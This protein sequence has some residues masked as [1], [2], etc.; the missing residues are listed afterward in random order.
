M[1]VV[2]ARLRNQR[3]TGSTIRRPEDVVAWMGALQAQDFAGARWAVGQR[4]SQATDDAVE[5]AF[6]DGRVLRTHVL[7]PTWH[8][9]HP[10]DIR[11]MLALTGPRVHQA[12]GSSYRSHDL[13][14]RRLARGADVICRA[15][16]GGRH[17]TRAELGAV[18]KAARL[19]HLGQPLAYLMMYAEL[20]ALVCSGP[21][22][23]KQF[24]YALMD[25]R[26]GGSRPSRQ[27]QD[28]RLGE[29]VRRYAASHG[30]ATLRDFAWWSGLTMAQ[31]RTGIGVAAS[32]LET[33][34]IDGRRHWW[35]AEAP[36]GP[37][38]PHGAYLLPNYDEFLIAFKDRQWSASMTALAPRFGPVV[39]FP[40]QI[41]IGGRVEGAWRVRRT[42]MHAC[43]ELTLYRPI[44]PA[45][46]AAVQ[47]AVDRY[48]AFLK[49]PV[50]AVEASAE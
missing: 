7:R 11:W 14:A 4:M 27:D 46:R 41:V 36:R 10:A 39:P 47:R 17:L 44:T 18:L 24:T 37:V 5:Q 48:A 31:A 45:E 3:L 22:R 38:R 42:N 29:L 20:E 16:E 8:L 1:N 9:V 28:E 40:H 35:A 6:N 50:T 25:E 33:A 49:T 2:A 32:S 12:N 26:V 23:G 19:P 13:D 43:L 21:R 34:E 15:L 30:P